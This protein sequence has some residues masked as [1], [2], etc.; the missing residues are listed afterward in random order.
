MVRQQR[1]GGGVR[2][3]EPVARKLFHQVKNFV[4]FFFSQ[5]IDACTFA[6]NTALCGHFFFVFF[7][8]C[9]AQNIR[10]AQRIAAQNLSRHHH[11]LLINHDA[12]GF[13]EHRLDARVRVFGLFLALLARDVARDQIHRAGPIQRI[14]RDQV[15]QTGRLGVSKHALHASTFKLKHRLGLTLSKQFVHP[16][17][18]ER[19]VF[20]RKIFLRRVPRG[21]EVLGYFQNG[22]RS[23]SQKVKLHQ[24]NGFHI[25]FVE[26]ADC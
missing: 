13:L 9:L 5:A 8:H 4:G 1:V 7:A 11:L 22:Q 2:L 16:R 6:K 3:V 17:I 26:L 20:K 14:H 15:F 10:T 21:D 24:P 23:Q 18:I 19:Q 12:V 25:V